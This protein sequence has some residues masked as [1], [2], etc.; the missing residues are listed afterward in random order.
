MNEI[1]AIILTL[2][3]GFGSLAGVWAWIRKALFAAKE[4]FD[5]AAAARDLIETVQRAE[6]DGQWTADEIQAIRDAA[7]EIKVEFDE[8]KGA[9]KGLSKLFG[10]KLA[11]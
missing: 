2:L 4:S 9:F 6:E 1:I 3:A 10:K 8:M 5:V 7:V 11:K